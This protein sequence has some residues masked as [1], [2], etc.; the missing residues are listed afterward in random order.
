MLACT[1]CLRRSTGIWGGIRRA[2]SH[3][4]RSDWKIMLKIISS[5]LRRLTLMPE[6]CPSDKGSDRFSPETIRVLQEAGW[7]PGRDLGGVV[8]EK[9]ESIIHDQYP[10]HV[11]RIFIEFGG[12]II[13]PG[14]YRSRLCDELC[15]PEIEK[16][17]GRKFWPAGCTVV[18]GDTDS[19]WVDD[20]GRVYIAFPPPEPEGKCISELHFFTDDFDSALNILV[21]RKWPHAP[22][23]KGIVKF[24]IKMNPRANQ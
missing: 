15:R 7:F 21:T 19:L 20:D 2:D 24:T 4:E 14:V 13:E 12:L 11:R 8:V 22:D 9:N 16:L 1:S 23:S 18:Y 3:V 6:I 5:I 10:E 17:T